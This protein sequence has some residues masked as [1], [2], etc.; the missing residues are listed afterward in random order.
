MFGVFRDVLP[1]LNPS[2]EKEA[3]CWEPGQV[4]RRL[5]VEGHVVGETWEAKGSGLVLSRAL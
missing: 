5:E 4:K 1:C 3:K 2:F